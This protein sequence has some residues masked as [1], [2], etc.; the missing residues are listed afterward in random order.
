MIET[1]KKVKVKMYSSF[2]LDALASDLFAG[3]GKKVL[4]R[5]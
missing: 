3:E 4:S 1:P 2:S 5:L